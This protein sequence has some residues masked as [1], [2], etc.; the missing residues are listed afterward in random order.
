[1]DGAGKPVIFRSE[2]GMSPGQAGLSA[3]V[4][5]A[6]HVSPKMDSLRLEITIAGLRFSASRSE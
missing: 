1:M 3:L 4:I 6:N 2:I 5:I